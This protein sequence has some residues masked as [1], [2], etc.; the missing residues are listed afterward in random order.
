MAIMASALQFFAALQIVVNVQA[1]D[2]IVVDVQTVDQT[3]AE[4]FVIEAVPVS[5]T[6]SLLH[7]S[8][9]YFC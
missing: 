1:M 2:R 4:N 5:V 7:T 3:G 8:Y 9:N 6:V